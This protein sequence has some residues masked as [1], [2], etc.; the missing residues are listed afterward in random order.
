[1]R[2]FPAGAHWRDA[3]EDGSVWVTNCGS[4]NAS[5]HISATEACSAL[6]AAPGGELFARVEC[7]DTRSATAID[8]QYRMRS[9]RVRRVWATDDCTGG[10]AEEVA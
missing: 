6:P 3:Q 5:A 10:E 9:E 7:S 1:M 8:R 2:R 4:T